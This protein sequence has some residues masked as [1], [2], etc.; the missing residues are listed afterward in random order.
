MAQASWSSVVRDADE[1][2]KLSDLGGTRVPGGTNPAEITFLRGYALEQLG[3]TEE[4][5][6]AYLSIPDG[7]NEYYG[8][9][10]TQ[11]FIGR[12]DRARSHARS[13]KM[14]LNALLNESKAATCGGPIR[15]GTCSGAIKPATD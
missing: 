11:R 13:C 14:R 15:A 3:R 1:L 10:A 2:L 5:I 7:R 6:A 9:R 4:A 12:G 8:T